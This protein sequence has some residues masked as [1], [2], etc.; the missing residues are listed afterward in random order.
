[1]TRDEWNQAC[2]LAA[3]FVDAMK[4]YFKSPV[5]TVDRAQVI[6]TACQILERE[7][8]SNFEKELGN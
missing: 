8:R 6:M 5:L 3:A 7:L 4:D 2:D 1:M